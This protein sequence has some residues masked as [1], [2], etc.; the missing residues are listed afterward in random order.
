MAEQVVAEGATYRTDLLP[1]FDLP[2]ARLLA[3]ADE[4][5]K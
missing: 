5:R 4:W 3:V 1:G 2:L